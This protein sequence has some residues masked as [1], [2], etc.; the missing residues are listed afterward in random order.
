M[1]NSRKYITESCDRQVVLFLPGEWV[2]QLNVIAS[3]RLISRVALIRSYIKV[4]LDREDN[5]KT[6]GFT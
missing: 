4:G 6:K 1:E 5:A 2:Q 3:N